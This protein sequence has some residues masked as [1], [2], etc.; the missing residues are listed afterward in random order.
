MSRGENLVSL[1]DLGDLPPS[2]EA[3]PFA[4]GVLVLTLRPFPGVFSPAAAATFFFP[5]VLSKTFSSALRVVLF[6]AASVFLPSPR[7]WKNPAAH[8][9]GDFPFVAFDFSSA[10][11]HAF[12]VS[13]SP[14]RMIAA[15]T[16]APC[17]PTHA[18]TS[19]ATALSH[20]VAAKFGADPS[21]SPVISSAARRSV[22]VEK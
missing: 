10:A 19:C 1:G 5:G 21:R 6:S 12:L 15:T 22:R 13:S 17:P 16:F 7:E 18:S 14:A 4:A 3:F 8:S 2:A 20:S 9:S 11:A